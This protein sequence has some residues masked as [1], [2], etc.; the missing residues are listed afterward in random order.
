MSGHIKRDR[1]G[2]CNM[3]HTHTHTH[4][5][6]ARATSEH[7]RAH[8]HPAHAHTLGMCY[9]LSEL[10]GTLAKEQQR[11][12]QKLLMA[13]SEKES[14]GEKQTG[15]EREQDLDPKEGEVMQKIKKGR[16]AGVTE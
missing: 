12:S 4:V 5:Q 1:T 16:G 7:L 11:D 14:E 6:E 8:T 3:Q 10:P 15:W 2:I 13:L 9:Q